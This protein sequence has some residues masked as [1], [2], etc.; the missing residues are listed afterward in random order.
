MKVK[1]PLSDE[2]LPIINKP[3]HP[4][5]ED[6]KEQN[7]KTWVQEHKKT[8]QECEPQKEDQVFEPPPIVRSISNKERGEHLKMTPKLEEPSPIGMTH[9]KIEITFTCY[10]VI[11]TL[12]L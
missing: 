10:N 5:K 7:G 3:K 2:T 4:M 6:Y 8:T 11:D 1:E 12:Y 9:L